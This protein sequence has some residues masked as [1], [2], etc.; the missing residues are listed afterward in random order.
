MCQIWCFYHKSHNS[1]IFLH[2]SAGLFPYN[3][4]LRYLYI[5]ATIKLTALLYDESWITNTVAACALLSVCISAV[6]ALPT[7]FTGVTSSPTSNPLKR[8][9]PPDKDNVLKDGRLSPATEW[10]ARR[11]VHWPP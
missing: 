6:S 8:W 5:W 7:T 4:K 9:R 2:Q 11:T 1:V 3:I 10:T